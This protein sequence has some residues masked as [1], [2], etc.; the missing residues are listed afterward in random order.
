MAKKSITIDGIE[1]VEKGSEKAKDYKGM[2]YCVIRTYSAGVFAAYVEKK[3][4]ENG[5]MCA[6]LQKSRRLW[7]WDGAASLSQ[8]SQEGVK[9]PNNCK[10][11]CEINDHEIAGVIEI[12]PCTKEAQESIN[13]VKIWEQ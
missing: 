9:K 5:L 12:I 3:W 10:F 1:Y 11:P 7:Y 2:T 8:L 6:L 13:K 4:V